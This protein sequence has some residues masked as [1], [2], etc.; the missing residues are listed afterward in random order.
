M[1]LDVPPQTLAAIV[2]VTASATKNGRAS[3]LDGQNFRKNY[4][5]EETSGY[6]EEI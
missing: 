2:D 5:K 4:E 1:I 6:S 3:W